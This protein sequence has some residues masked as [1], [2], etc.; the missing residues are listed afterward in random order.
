MNSSST[1]LSQLLTTTNVS[2]GTSRYIAS[3]RTPRKTHLL[4]S[5]IVLGV[6]TDLLHSNRRPVA[7]RVVSRVDV[8]TESLPSN[9]SIRHNINIDLREIGWSAMDWINLPHGRDGWR[10]FVHTTMK[11]RIL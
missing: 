1:E 4:L 2:V 11:L 3:E 10:A 8:F 9:G 6:F 5:H 7:A